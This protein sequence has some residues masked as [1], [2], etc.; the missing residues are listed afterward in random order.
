VKDVLKYIPGIGWGMLFLDCLFVKRNWHSDKSKIHG[1]FN[2]FHREKIPAW[3]M[4][5][6]EGTRFTP[7]KL[8]RSHKIAER[9]GLPVT[10]KVLLPRTKGFTASVEGLK[11][12]TPAIYDVTIKYDQVPSISQFICGGPR[13]VD[14]T[15]KRFSLDQLVNDRIDLEAWL[16]QQFASKDAILS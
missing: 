8:E 5:F 16:Y 12:H 2:K 3:T 10:K 7:A 11:G 4:I 1:L 15:V 14:V 6:P 13:T 9:K